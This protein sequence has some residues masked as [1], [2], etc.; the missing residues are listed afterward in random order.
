[1]QEH[2]NHV[3]AWL[4][5]EGVRY[6]F[7]K[8]ETFMCVYK[9]NVPKHSTL[10]LEMCSW[11]A[12]VSPRP[13]VSRFAPYHGTTSAIILSHKV[14][15]AHEV[16]LVERDFYFTEKSTVISTTYHDTCVI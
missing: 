15:Q 4:I 3:D 14:C 11:G 2:F 1:M 13:P 5:E 16:Q 10:F 12:P 9:H 6:R 8:K 7:E